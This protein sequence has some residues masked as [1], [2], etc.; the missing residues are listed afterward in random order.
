MF[1]RHYLMSVAVVM[2]GVLVL[3]GRFIHDGRLGGAGYTNP[4]ETGIVTD[5]YT[6][7][8]SPAARSTWT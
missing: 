1:L 6:D 4:T 5:L 2:A 3:L 7:S 8:F